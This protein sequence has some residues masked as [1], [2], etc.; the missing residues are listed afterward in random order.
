MPLAYH[1]MISCLSLAHRYFYYEALCSLVPA[2]DDQ[3]TSATYALRCLCAQKLAVISVQVTYNDDY[4]SSRIIK[5]AL[6][7]T[8]CSFICLFLPWMRTVMIM[9]CIGMSKPVSIFVLLGAEL[10]YIVKLILSLQLYRLSTWLEN[11]CG[12]WRLKQAM[13]VTSSKNASIFEKQ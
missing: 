11:L 5:V 7:L 6:Y 9:W 2:T 3:A 10:R 13:N 8:F 12:H 4:R 1:S